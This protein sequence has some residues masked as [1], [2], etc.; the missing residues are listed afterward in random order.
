M[1]CHPGTTRQ[2]TRPV[3]TIIAALCLAA[4]TGTKPAASFI[5]EFS[6]EITGDGTKFFTYVRNFSGGTEPVKTL[7]K[8]VQTRLETTGY[9]R[10]GYLTLERYHANGMARIRGECRDGASDSDR[11]RFPNRP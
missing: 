4:C 8:A 9:C 11:E 7:D 6:T 10:D 5:D 2:S 3:L 1:I